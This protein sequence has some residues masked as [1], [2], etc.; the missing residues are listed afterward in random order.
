MKCRG[1]NRSLNHAFSSGV[2]RYKS[3]FELAEV[4]IGGA[5]IGRNPSYETGIRVHGRHRQSQWEVAWKEREVDSWSES[6][7]SDQTHGRDAQSCAHRYV[8]SDSSIGIT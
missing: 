7:S 1:E 4:K 5:S 6:T 8:D 2:P 3:I